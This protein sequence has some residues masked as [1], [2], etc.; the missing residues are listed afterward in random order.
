MLFSWGE[1]GSRV[2]IA[3]WRNINRSMRTSSDALSDANQ[4]ANSAKVKGVFQRSLFLISLDSI[5]SI[6]PSES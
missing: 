6:K 5:F 3:D 1:R 4:P 2:E